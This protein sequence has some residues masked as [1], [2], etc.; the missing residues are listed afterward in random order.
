MITITR[1]TQFLNLVCSDCE[2][3]AKS[4][5]RSE[6]YPFLNKRNNLGLLRRVYVYRHIC[7]IQNQLPLLT[8]KK[9][10]QPTTFPPLHV[11]PLS[12]RHPS[13]GSISIVSHLEKNVG[14]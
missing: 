12:L 9:W 8:S 13:T 5:R 14:P 4:Q 6:S 7:G 10:S 2:S 3:F 11:S 1:S